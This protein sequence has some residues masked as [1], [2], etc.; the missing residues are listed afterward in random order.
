MFKGYHCV[1]GKTGFEKHERMHTCYLRV[2]FLIQS[3][4]KQVCGILGRAVW[5]IT[6]R[7]GIQNS[8]VTCIS[9]KPRKNIQHYK[10]Q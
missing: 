1:M 5:C 7:K 4:A 10:L 6:V 3:N 9:E 8:E 2:Q